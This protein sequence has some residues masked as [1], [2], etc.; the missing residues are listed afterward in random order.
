MVKPSLTPSRIALTPVDVMPPILETRELCVTAGARLILR[1]VSLSLQPRRVVGIIGP[2]GAGKSTFLKCLNRLIELT[3]GLDVS[4]E[5]LFH[6]RSIYLRS[7]DADAIRAKIGILFQQPV[8]FP[9]TILK[10]VLFGVRH[11]GRH[12]KSEWGNIA[13]RALKEVA[14]WDEVKDRLN[15]S[16]MRLSVGQQQRL[17]LARTLAVDPEVVL[18]DEPTSALD[19]KSTEAIEGLIIQL[20]AERTVILVTHN[21][22]QA[23]RVSDSMVSITPRNGVGEV[24]GC[25]SCDDLIEDSG[26]ECK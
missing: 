4:G 22:A 11:L 15:E 19:P 16:A 14:I 5:V 7:V 26:T 24:S 8:V 6:G 10:N 23:R 12:P 17:C 25:G 13:E 3:P 2:S 18:M 9:T 21:L 20:K 1:N